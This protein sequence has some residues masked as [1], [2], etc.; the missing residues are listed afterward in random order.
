M[1]FLVCL[2]I[3]SAIGCAGPTRTAG[4]EGIKPE[5][6]AVLRV[7]KQ[8]DVEVLQLAA[9]QFDDGDKYKIDG[10]RDF[11]LTP[12]AHHIAIDLTAKIDS[13]VKWV[14]IPDTK[15]AGPRGLTTGDLKPGKT[16][17]LSG[18]SGA[19]QGMMAGGELGIT[20]EM[21]TK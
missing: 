19:V 13:P 12:G 3:V 6:L 9:I 14:K 1:R 11:Y 7:A 16:Y 4:T 17:E 20:R 10:D 21:A 8:Y 18:L 2:L 5:K 15:I